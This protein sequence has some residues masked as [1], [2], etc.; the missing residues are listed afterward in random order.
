MINKIAKEIFEFCKY[1]FTDDEKGYI[2]S[3]LKQAYQ[4]GVIDT[5]QEQLGKVRGKLVL[6]F[7]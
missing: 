2:T 7:Y 5:L 3:S 6:Q 4:Q 1:K